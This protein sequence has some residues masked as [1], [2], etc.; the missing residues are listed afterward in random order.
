ML[1]HD[2]YSVTVCPKIVKQYTVG[3]S[4]NADEYIMVGGCKVSRSFFEA[5]NVFENGEPVSFDSIKEG[6][7]LE[8]VYNGEILTSMPGQFGHID[9]IRVVSRAGN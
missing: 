5:G 3:Y 9:I 6:D 4:P 2:V 7:V 8:V 1:Y